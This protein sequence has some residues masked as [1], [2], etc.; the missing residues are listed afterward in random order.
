MSNL[1]IGEVHLRF[2]LGDA[3]SQYLD[4]TLTT[5]ELQGWDMSKRELVDLEDLVGD[6]RAKV[7][8]SI[9]LGDKDFGNGFEAHC[10]VQ[11]TVNQD[12]GS[13]EEAQDW[14]TALAEGHMEVAFKAAEDQYDKVRPNGGTKREKR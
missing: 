13:I 5:D 2:R 14:A 9:S 11:L 10:S 7:T 3:P 4:K 6:G 8:A 12:K 1:P